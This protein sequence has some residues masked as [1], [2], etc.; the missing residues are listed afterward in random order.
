MSIEAMASVLHHSRAKGSAKLLLLG[1]ANHQGDQGAWP[2]ITTL[3]KYTGTSERRVQQMLRELEELGELA[4]E[5]QKGYSATNRYYVRVNCPG[6]CDRSTNHKMGEA[7]FRGGVKL[8]SGVG[9]KPTSPEPSLE[10][11]ENP[12]R[13]ATRIPEDFEPTSEMLDWAAAEH[14]RVDADLE[15]KA[16]VDYW[17]STA[18][19]PTKTDWNRTWKNWIRSTDRRMGVSGRRESVIEQNVNVIRRMM[20]QD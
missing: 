6:D 20:G 14:P 5:Y 15:T 10:P 11:S 16:F 8:A 2:A 18:K 13:R 19:N 1:I 17:L 9:V 7:H 3:A 4:I 12:K